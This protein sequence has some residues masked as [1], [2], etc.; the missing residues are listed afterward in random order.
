MSF[1]GDLEFKLQGTGGGPADISVKDGDAVQDG[2]LDTSI[3]ISLFTDSR[4]NEEE[5]KKLQNPILYSGGWFG[6]VFEGMSL[7]NKAWLLN[8]SKI[9]QNVLNQ[10]QEQ[11]TNSLKW[12]VEEGIADSVRVSVSQFTDGIEINVKVFR[13]QSTDNEYKYFYNWEN[14]ISK[15]S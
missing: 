7:G 9:T 5:R 2:G 8:K 14:Q 3:L 13:A 12:L 4:V 15:G 6:E 1:T 11:F 10:F